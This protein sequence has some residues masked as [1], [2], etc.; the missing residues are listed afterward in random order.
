MRHSDPKLTANV[1]THLGLDDTSSAIEQMNVLVIEDNRSLPFILK[2]AD[3]D[4]DN[5]DTAIDF[6]TIPDHQQ[7]AV[8]LT[9]N[10]N[11]STKRG[12]NTAFP[13]DSMDS[14]KSIKKSANCFQGN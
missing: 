3:S 12:Q 11:K 5:S 9:T 14:R 1:Y 4:A 6:E 2:D 8:E 13:S 7:V 10:S